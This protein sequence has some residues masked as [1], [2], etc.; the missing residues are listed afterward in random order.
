MLLDS[1]G[2]R[3]QGVN[4]LQDFLFRQKLGEAGY[5]IGSA[6]LGSADAAARAAR[7]ANQSGGKK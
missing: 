5:S 3:R 6:Q 7:E 4:D 2:M 1:A